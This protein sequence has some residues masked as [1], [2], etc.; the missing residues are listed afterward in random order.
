MYGNKYARCLYFWRL[1]PSIQ[2]TIFKEIVET[3]LSLTISTNIEFVEPDVALK[4]VRRQ[5]TDMQMERSGKTKKIAE[6]SGGVVIVETKVVPSPLRVHHSRKIPRAQALCESRKGI[7]RGFARAKSEN[8]TCSIYRYAHWRQ[9]FG[10]RN[11][12]RKS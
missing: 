9:L 5:L 6:H 4:L 3:N 7:F 11:E 10:T 1:P 8:D 2:D 12:H